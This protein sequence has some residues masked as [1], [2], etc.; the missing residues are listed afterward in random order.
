VTRIPLDGDWQLAYFPEGEWQV[1]HPDNLTAVRAVPARVPG[2]VELDLMRAGVIPDPFYAANVR[3]LLSFESYEWWYTREFVLPQEAAGQRWDLVFAGL[4]TLATV[5]V[6]GVEVGRAANMLIEHRFDVTHALKPGAANRIAVRLGSAL[7]HARQFHYDAHSMSWEHRE[8]GLFIRK[9]PHV[10]G[11][12]IM[13]RA[14]SAGLWRPVWLEVRLPTAVEQVYYWTA[15]VGAEGAT[16]GVRFQFRT[17]A[18]TLDGFKM[19]FHG[20]CGDHVFEFEWPVEFVAGGCRIPVPGARLWWPK[21]YGEPNLYTVT[22]QLCKGERVLAERVDRIGIRSLAVERSVS[23]GAPWSPP[24]AVASAARVDVPPDADGRFLF[25]VNGEPIMVKGANWVPLDGFHSRDAER[26]DQAVA[27]FDDLGCNMVR[28]WGGNVYEG[29][30]FFDLCDEQGILVWQDLAFACCRYPQTEEFLAQVR[31]EVQA[32]AERL[33]N[34]PSLALWCGDNEV[35]M[36][37]V[38]DGLSPEHNRL[39]RQVVPLVL[40]RCDPQRAYVPSSPYVSPAAASGPDP[41]GRAPEQH[42]WGPRGYFKSPFYTQ[43]SAHFI[44]EIGYHGCPNVSSIQRFISPKKLWPWQDAGGRRNDEWQVHAVY[45]WQHHA[46]ER[47]R[48]QLMANQVRELFG[49]IPDDL[50]EFALASQITQAE[51]KKFFVEST[52][53]RKWRTSGILW[54]NVLDGWPQFSDAVVDYYFG[55]KLAYH[56]LWRVQ[57]PVCLIVGESGPGKYLPLVV[58]NDTREPAEVHYRAWDA[59]G[60]ETVAEGEFEVPANQNWQVGRIRTYAGQQRLY[61]I[62]WEVAG[63][64][65]GNHYLAGWPPFSLARYREWLPAIAA[66]P[67]PFDPA[68][69]AR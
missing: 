40:H 13:P 54:W 44:G 12:D 57:R 18:P 64:A 41:L 28:C 58:S 62:A 1:T 61:L 11:W 42:L 9:A 65:Y 43:H 25:V 48:I 3:H 55:K 56:Y 37:Y 51:A 39:T 15:E 22:A 33:R 68:Q 8:E 24:P 32:V 31:A 52:R 45:H 30:H 36:I 6:N 49:T 66:L 29:D 50:E 60:R 47:D 53:L 21:G 38:A 69:V 23:A 5:W 7:R 14:V 63:Q 2:N 4:D 46:I 19:R 34:H 16:L 20:V 67:R 17:P 35:D 10:W 26:V 59:E 27:L